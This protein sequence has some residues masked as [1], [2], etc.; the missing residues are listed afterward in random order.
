MPTQP[1]MP[2]VALTKLEIHEDERGRFAEIMRATQ[3][4][5]TFVQSNHSYSKTGV[6]RGLH[7]HQHQADLWYVVTGRARVGLAD[8]RVP[9]EITTA[10]LVL[11][12][13]SPHS[14][15]IPHGVAHGF[16]AMT[17][18]NLV[19]WVTNYYD[20][21]DEYGVAWNDPTLAINWDI[22]EPIISERDQANPPLKW[23]TI[24]SFA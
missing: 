1:D 22:A 2:G 7:Y 12:G 4:P 20:S 11:E 8:L 5:E 10:T 9:G 16:A 6:V 18:V 24:P 13:A 23:D 14:L 19:Y 3:F 15:Y 17:D 21:S